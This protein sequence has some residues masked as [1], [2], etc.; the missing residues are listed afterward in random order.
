MRATPT[1][2][3]PKAAMIQELPIGA[4]SEQDLLSLIKHFHGSQPFFTFEMYY[5]HVQANG[6][7][8]GIQLVR[9]QLTSEQ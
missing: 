4:Y 6:I 1:A 2:A 9:E 8:K 7:H 3:A 5:E